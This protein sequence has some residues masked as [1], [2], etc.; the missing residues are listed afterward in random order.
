MSNNFEIRSGSYFTP[1]TD[2]NTLKFWGVHSE[3]TT[4]IAVTNTRKVP[5]STIPYFLFNRSLGQEGIYQLAN[6]TIQDR[7]ELVFEIGPGESMSPV[8]CALNRNRRTVIAFDSHNKPEH[9][10]VA[11]SIEITHPQ[12][13]GSFAVLFNQNF[14]TLNTNKLPRVKRVQAI[15][16]FPNTIDDIVTFG[17]QISEQVIII[18]NPNQKYQTGELS[19]PLPQNSKSEVRNLSL[20][21][22]EKLIGTISSSFID[23]RL[24]SNHRLPVIVITTT[25]K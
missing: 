14:K 16:P 15:V 1:P 12:Y 19:H 24:P 3:H 6:A 25:L 23:R 13:E 2:T 22:I 4:S 9:S 5:I 11:G 21:E 7:R 20:L 17:T 10:Y 18:P 8:N